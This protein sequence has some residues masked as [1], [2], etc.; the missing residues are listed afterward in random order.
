MVFGKSNF[1][2]FIAFVLI[3]GI[4]GTALGSLV[5]SLLPILAVLKSNV[6]PNAEINLVV[7]SV[8]FNINPVTLAGMLLGIVF[9]IKL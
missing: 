6:V 3:G 7:M 8:S 5:G 9:F 4:L 2:F 1:G